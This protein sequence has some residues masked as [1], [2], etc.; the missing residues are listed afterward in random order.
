MSA[1]QPKLWKGV[2]VELP[3]RGE[4]GVIRQVKVGGKDLHWLSLSPRSR[5][6]PWREPFPPSAAML[7][8]LSLLICT[9]PVLGLLEELNANEPSEPPAL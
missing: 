1:A 7:W 5:P 3:E 4:G 8:D 9:T 2:P 6:K